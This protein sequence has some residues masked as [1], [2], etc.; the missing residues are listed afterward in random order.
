MSAESPAIDFPIAGIGASAGGL[1]DFEAF[2]SG[3]PTS[4]DLNLAFVLAQHLAPEVG[5]GMA[6]QPNC[7]FVLPRNRDM[8]FQRGRLWL[9]EPGAPRGQCLP[10]DV[11]FNPLAQDQHERAMV[12]RIAGAASP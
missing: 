12:V 11:F 8:A 6:V 4:A 1:G 7:V 10:I 9:R 2:F 3:M 5:Y